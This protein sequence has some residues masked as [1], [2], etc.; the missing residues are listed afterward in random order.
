MKNFAIEIKWGIIFVLVGIVWVFIEKSLGYHDEKIASQVLFSFLFVPIA[1][2]IF[3]LGLREKKQKFYTNAIT[4]RQSF[5]SGIL[6]SVVVAVCS[7]LSQY[8]VLEL[9]SPD[10]LDNMSALAIKNKKMSENEALAYF[11]LNNYMWQ[12]VYFALSTGVVTSAIVSLFIRTKPK[13]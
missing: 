6:I 5:V 11:N 9:I 4:W 3:F 13:S 10:Y 12:S 8:V 2:F 7:P 1:F